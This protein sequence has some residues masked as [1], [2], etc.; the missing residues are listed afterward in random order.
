MQQDLGLTI[1][2]IDLI[3]IGIVVYC[4]WRGYRNGLI[5]GAFGVVALIV[6]LLVANIAASAYSEEFEG[7]LNPFVGGIVDTAFADLSM[8]AFEYDEIEHDNDSEQFRDAYNALREIGLPIPAA[9]KIAELAVEDGQDERSL[10]TMVAE[11]LSSTLSYIAVFAVAFALMAIIF[12]VIGNLIGFVFALPGLKLLDSII[13]VVFGLAKGLIVV[14][15][16]GAIVRYF[17]LLAIDI[18][19]ETIILNHLVN[20]NIIAEMLGI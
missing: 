19:E 15:T 8:D 14:L 11:R 18:L 9:I 17:G 20:N 2:F 16:I 10:P 3:I 5:R 6:C 7:A 13:G 1:I 4:A 12:A